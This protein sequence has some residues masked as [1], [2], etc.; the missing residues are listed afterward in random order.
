MKQLSD[1]LDGAA[2]YLGPISIEEYNRRIDQICAFCREHP[3]LEEKFLNEVANNLQWQE[4]AKNTQIQF[5][6][7]EPLRLRPGDPRNAHVE[8]GIF[9]RIYDGGKHPV[10]K[11]VI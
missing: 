5:Y 2:Y 4:L 3:D 11:V 10:I 1:Y 7:E 8:Y 9:T 6:V